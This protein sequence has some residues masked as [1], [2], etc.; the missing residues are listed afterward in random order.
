MNNYTA[1][2]RQNVKENRI[3][4]LFYPLLVLALLG[5]WFFPSDARAAAAAPEVD[6]GDWTRKRLTGHIDLLVD[7]AGTLTIDRVASPEFADRFQFP[8]PRVPNLGLTEHTVWV[9]FTVRNRSDSAEKLQL[10]F[11][12]PVTDKV[13]LY[14]PAAGGGFREIRAGDSVVPSPE[15]VKHRFMVFPLEVPPGRSTYHLRIQTT[16]GM[17]LPLSLWRP[18]AFFRQ[19]SFDHMTY[20]LLFGAVLVFVFYFFVV[21]ARLSYPA[22]AWFAAYIV[23]LSTHAAVRS[24]IGALVLGDPGIRLNNLFNVAVIGLLFCVGA[25]FMRVFLELRSNSLKLDRTLALLQWMGLFYPVMIVI[26]P[27][28][29]L[30][31]YSLV[32]FLIG[33]VFSSSVSVLMWRRGI[34]AAGFFAIGWL[35]GHLTSAMD[36]L[37]I[38]G[39]LGYYPWMSLLIPISVMSSLAFF[40]A[41]IVERIYSYKI[42]S[43]QDSLTQLANRRLLDEVLAREW[44]RCRRHGRPLALLMIDVDHFKAYND[45]YGH[46]AGDRRLMEAAKVLQRYARRSGDLAAR[47]GGEEFVLVLSETDVKTAFEIAET[48]RNEIKAARM[49]QADSKAETVLTVSIGVSAVV[50]ETDAGMNDLIRSA[51][52]ALYRAKADGRDCCAVSAAEAVGETVL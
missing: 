18:E 42:D 16:A 46:K 12:Y 4:S 27:P 35:I 21:A 5:A 33:P 15:V 31:V 19:D 44:N 2:F 26:S 22:A 10:S 49:S 29:P 37:R 47:Y 41:A 43:Q 7:P 28:G 39:V 32:L 20:G 50:P 48:I 40:S 38:M 9:R 8:G 24:G 1:I 52:E 13:Y 34:P 23:L 6:I 36:S 30:I 51:D 45:T 3:A 14:R 17:T 11:E 25:K